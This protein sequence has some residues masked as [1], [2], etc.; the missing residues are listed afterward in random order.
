MKVSPLT[1]HKK[2]SKDG[3]VSGFDRTE[4]FIKA[5]KEFDKKF[6]YKRPL[7]E[8]YEYRNTMD[9]GTNKEKAVLLEK[10]K[11]SQEQEIKNAPGQEIK[12]EADQKKEEKK[13]KDK[14]FSM[15]F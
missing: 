13:D 11:L 12:K 7:S 1:N 14:G 6:D 15:G 9:K 2:E 10:E 3:K 8:S 5:E 4:F